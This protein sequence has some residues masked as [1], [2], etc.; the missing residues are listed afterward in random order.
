M[1][2]ILQTNGIT[3]DR[4]LSE[5]YFLLLSIES[6]VKSFLSF[7]HVCHVATMRAHCHSINSSLEWPLFYDISLISSR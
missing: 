3:D 7:V 6:E 2:T 1:F 5:S 4:D